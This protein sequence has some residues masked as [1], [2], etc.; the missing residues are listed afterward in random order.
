MVN[1]HTHWNIFDT[2]RW[3]K[4]HFDNGSYN[5]FRIRM[6]NIQMIFPLLYSYKFHWFDKQNQSS[7][8]WIG[9]TRTDSRSRTDWIKERIGVTYWS[10][11]WSSKPWNFPQFAGWIPSALWSSKSFH[12]FQ[13]K[14]RFFH[15]ISIARSLII[16]QIFLDGHCQPQHSDWRT[17]HGHR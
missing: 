4:I 16:S 8:S 11:L 7:Y 6:M 15:T 9:Q 13:R 14:K 10:G 5:L 1:F 17:K 2:G 3:E 12:D